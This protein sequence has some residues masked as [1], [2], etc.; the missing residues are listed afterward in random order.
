MTAARS[1][2]PPELAIDLRDYM[3]FLRRLWWVPVTLALAGL[4]AGWALAPVPPWESL[5]RAAVVM[6]GDTEDPGSSERPELM[7]LDDLLSLVQ[8]RVF[9]ERTLEAI[10]AGNRGTLTVTEVQ[11]A[12]DET[13]YGRVATVIVSGPDPDEVS[14]IV[15]AA[16]SVFPDAVN[17]YLVAPGAQPANIQLLDPPSEPERSFARRSLT[18]VAAA[19]VSFM[20]GMWIVWIVGAKRFRGQ[21]GVRAAQPGT[22]PDRVAKNSSR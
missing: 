3:R 8:S 7:I 20:A 14:A 17:A 5:F 21:S 6:P 18:I 15:S 11:A 10:P 1:G 16:A 22:E 13:R 4:V 9:A 19:F 12:L 2:T